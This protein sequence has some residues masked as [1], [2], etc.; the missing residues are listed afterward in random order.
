MLMLFEATLSLPFAMPT[1]TVAATSIYV[2][3]IKKAVLTL[4]LIVGVL[5][6]FLAACKHFFITLDIE[7]HMFNGTVIVHVNNG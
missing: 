1:V 3:S 6:P 7:V 2:I 4:T 5:V